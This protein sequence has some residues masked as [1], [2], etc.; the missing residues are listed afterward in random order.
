MK[1]DLHHFEW[2]KN[3]A[4]QQ[5]AFNKTMAQQR[6][7]HREEWYDFYP[8]AEKLRVQ[9]QDQVLL[10]DVGGGKGHDLIKFHEKHRDL[11]GKLIVQD[12]PAVIDDMSD[13]L[14]ARIEAQKYDFFTPQTIRGAKAYYLRTVLHDWPDK[15]A[16][17]ILKNIRG[18]MA[19]D[20]VL[21]INEGCLE[22][23]GV[24][25]FEAE[26]DLSMMVLFASLERTQVQWN[27]LLEDAGF[28]IT[29][30]YK[31][32]VWTPGSVTLFEAVGA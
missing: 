15:Q 4:R 20:S 7:G 11:A 14:P 18:V 31:P 21:L 13:P 12:L 29:G 17:E 6:M 10:V 9:Q 26:L 23:Q 19:E 25:L 3:Y 16:L 2:L 24:S 22:E 27:K 5:V 30:I 8:V 28:K 32:R 1:T